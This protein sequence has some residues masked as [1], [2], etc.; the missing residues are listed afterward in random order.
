MIDNMGLFEKKFK[1][2]GVK[3]YFLV[4]PPIPVAG[5]PFF[6]SILTNNKELSNNQKLDYCTIERSY[7]KTLL[8]CCQNS[9]L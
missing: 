9:D 5:Q 6:N 8:V 1:V 7:H 4:K 3:F 2:R